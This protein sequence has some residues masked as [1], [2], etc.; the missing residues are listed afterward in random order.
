MLEETCEADPVVGQMRFFADDDDVVFP[1]LHIEL[2]ELLNE[3][4]SHHAQ[5]DDHDTLSSSRFEYLSIGDIIFL[6]LATWAIAVGYFTILRKFLDRFGENVR[7]CV[8]PLAV[9]HLDCIVTM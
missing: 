5:S 8:V 4:N 3:A 6:H 2:H 7:F 9:G 1:S